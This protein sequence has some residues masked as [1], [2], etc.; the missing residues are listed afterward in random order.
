MSY[1]A[2][3]ETLFGFAKSLKRF[4]FYAYV[5][6][7]CNRYTTIDYA[8]FHARYPLSIKLTFGQFF[9][10]SNNLAFTPVA[11]LRE[12]LDAGGSRSQ[13]HNPETWSRQSALASVGNW[14]GLR[15]WQDVLNAGKMVSNGNGK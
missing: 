1:R 11:R 7:L 10:N 2:R 15:A 13:I 3:L 5:I 8:N 9:S 14:E 4:I 6:S 12:I